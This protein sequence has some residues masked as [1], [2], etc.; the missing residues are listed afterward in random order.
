[1]KGAPPRSPRNGCAGWPCSRGSVTS[2]DTCRESAERRGAW[3]ARHSFTSNQSF[4]SDLRMPPPLGGECG[5]RR[6]SNG[7]SPFKSFKASQTQDPHER[8]QA[9]QLEHGALTTSWF[10][11]LVVSAPTGAESRDVAFNLP[12]GAQDFR[13]KSGEAVRGAVQSAGL[14]R[15]GGTFPCGPTSAAPVV[16]LDRRAPRASLLHGRGSA[17]RT[18]RARSSGQRRRQLSSALSSSVSLPGS[19]GPML[20]GSGSPYPSHTGRCSPFRWARAPP[21]VAMRSPSG[22]HVLPLTWPCAPP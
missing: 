22:G 19:D 14:R 18:L 21:H 8:S 4:K 11:R 17:Q 20:P 12:P 15:A 10:W 16:P 5:G 1:M 3:E 7:S 6:S 13:R 9:R 2:G